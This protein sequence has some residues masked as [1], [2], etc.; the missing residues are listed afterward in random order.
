METSSNQDPLNTEEVNQ[1]AYSFKKSL[2]VARSII[3]HKNISR[4]GLAR[5]MS[6]VL[7]FPL[8]DKE[9][10][11]RDK[12]EHQLFVLTINTLSAKNTM[13]TA[14]INNQEQTAAKLAE[15]EQ[16][17]KEGETSGQ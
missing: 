7:E 5:V 1:A 13:M 6:A 11:F 9:P 15:A 2:E 8:A 14:I 10:K 12:F 4:N 3:G 16:S 17:V